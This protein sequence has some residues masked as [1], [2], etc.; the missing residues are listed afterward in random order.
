MVESYCAVITT[1]DSAEAAGKLGRRIV[2]ARL[3]ACVQIVGPIRSI[4]GGKVM[5]MMNRNGNA[6]LRP[7]LIDWKP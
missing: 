4:I 2:Q 6:G 1:T 5:Y 7:A 3:G